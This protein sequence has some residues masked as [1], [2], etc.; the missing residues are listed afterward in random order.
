MIIGDENF[1][2][3][4]IFI[5]TCEKFINDYNIDE[6]INSVYYKTDIMSANLALDRKMKNREF[7]P[8]L[9]LYT[10]GAYVEMYKNMV[11]Y[12]DYCIIFS[13]DKL[14]KDLEILVELLKINNKEYIIKYKNKIEEEW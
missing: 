6:I 12:T 9:I 11:Q 13:S 3:E 10:K 7:V 1:D 4:D 2:N 8:D 5:E 14:T